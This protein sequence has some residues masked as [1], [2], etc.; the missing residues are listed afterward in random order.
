M[1]SLDRSTRATDD[2]VAS[3]LHALLILLAIGMLIAPWVL[4]G[5]IPFLVYWGVQLVHPQYLAITA[6]LTAVLMSSF[7]GTG[8]RRHHRRGHDGHGGG[9]GCAAAGDC[10]RDH[11]RCVLVRQ[12]VAVVR[13]HNSRRGGRRR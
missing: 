3:V 5:T 12:N 8:I 13:L 6:F 4:S 10:R 11:L 1:A 7:T 9:C 2:T